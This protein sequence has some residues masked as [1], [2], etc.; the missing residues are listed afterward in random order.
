MKHQ[1]CNLGYVLNTK[2]ILITN[3]LYMHHSNF[4]LRCEH[5]I[6]MSCKVNRNSVV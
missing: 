6:F 3:V 2:I 4:D 5:Y 1:E